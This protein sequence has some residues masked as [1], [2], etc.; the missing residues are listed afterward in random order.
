M[1][2]SSDREDDSGEDDNGE[3]DGA[4]NGTKRRK[5]MDDVRMCYEYDLILIFCFARMV[6]V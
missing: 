1:A 2:S 5:V 3:D 6:D 4:Q